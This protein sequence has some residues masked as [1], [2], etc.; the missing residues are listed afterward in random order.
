MGRTN[1]VLDDEL[2]KK[3][4]AA[5]GL[6]TRRE[7]IDYALREV[8]RHKNQRRLLELKGRVNWEGDLETMRSSRV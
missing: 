1:V 4:L 3:C 2:V 7:L 8:L 6:K 5:T